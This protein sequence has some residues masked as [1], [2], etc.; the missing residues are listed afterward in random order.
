MGCS[1]LCREGSRERCNCSR[2]GG[3]RVVGGSEMNTEEIQSPRARG[4][5]PGERWFNMENSLVERR[6]LHCL[7]RELNSSLIFKHG[8]GLRTSPLWV[9]CILLG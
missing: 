4:E 6:S 8:G 9:V 3:G 2:C 1:P 5:D 7:E